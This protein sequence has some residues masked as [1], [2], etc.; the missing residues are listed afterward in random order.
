VDDLPDSYKRY[1]MNYYR[2]SLKVMGTPIRIEFREGA[3]P[4][5]GKKNSLTI[6]QQRKRKRLMS[7]HQ[8]K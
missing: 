1:L 2:K 6:S 5:E 8:K 3:N 4:F 7:F